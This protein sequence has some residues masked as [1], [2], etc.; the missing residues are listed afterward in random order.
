VTV[1][2]LCPDNCADCAFDTH[3]EPSW[4]DFTVVPART[5]YARKRACVNPLRATPFVSDFQTRS[6]FETV[7]TREVL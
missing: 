1:F 2:N 3:E 4:N 7:R 5:Y 6:I